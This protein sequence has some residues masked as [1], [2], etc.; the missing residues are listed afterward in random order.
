VKYGTKM[1]AAKRDLVVTVGVVGAP[2]S[3]IE[4]VVVLSKNSLPV[5]QIRVICKN[6]PQ[7]SM[8]NKRT[9]S[10][11]KMQISYALIHIYMMHV[12]LKFGDIGWCLVSY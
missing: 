12:G 9:F 7:V 1:A 5:A 8:T 4:L 6:V 10:Q 3:G 2:S 11:G